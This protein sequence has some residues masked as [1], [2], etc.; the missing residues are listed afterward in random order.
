M[1]KEKFL[2]WTELKRP[3]EKSASEL[4]QPKVVLG[5]KSQTSGFVRGPSRRGLDAKSLP[6]VSGRSDNRLPI[7]VHLSEAE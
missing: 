7:I 3:N 4:A 1:F 5:S 2:D 6:T